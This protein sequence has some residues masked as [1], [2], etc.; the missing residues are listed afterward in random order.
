MAINNQKEKQ[1]IDTSEKEESVETN[2]QPKVYLGIFQTQHDNIAKGKANQIYAYNWKTFNLKHNSMEDVHKEHPYCK[3]PI[4]SL[5]HQFMMLHLS[6][7]YDFWNE[8]V[9]S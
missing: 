6:D 2:K 7:S 1:T 9:K 3:D 4:K 5:N 8:I